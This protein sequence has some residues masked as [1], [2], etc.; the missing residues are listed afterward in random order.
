INSGHRALRVP[1]DATF[2][3][4][5]RAGRSPK[6]CPSNWW[7][8]EP[9]LSA[10]L[11]TADTSDACP[12]HIARGFEMR[13]VVPKRSTRIAAVCVALFG[14]WSLS[15]APASA[16]SPHCTGTAFDYT[17]TVSQV[18]SPKGCGNY[19]ARAQ[20]S[21]SGST[22]YSAFG[23]VKTE[24]QFPGV[25]TVTTRSAS[26]AGVP[27]ASAPQKAQTRSHY[28]GGNYGYSAWMNS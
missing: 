6:W 4:G 14:F 5:S 24:A 2:V 3:G 19:Q 12:L 26:Y 25:N 28:G 23:A 16:A 1:F 7:L 11:C 10:S 27:N 17:S 13:M 8:A 15:S 22:A 18:N 20:Y 21:V 9:P